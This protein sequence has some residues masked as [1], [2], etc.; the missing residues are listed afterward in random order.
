[1]LRE[2]PI[3]VVVT[4]AILPHVAGAGLLGQ[5]QE[6]RPDVQVIMIDG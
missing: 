2:S 6:A 1:M 5:M 4:D 3:D